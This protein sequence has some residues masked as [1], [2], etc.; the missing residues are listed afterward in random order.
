MTG[1][2][3]DTPWRSQ[4]V[5]ALTALRCPLALE[6]Y[7][8]IYEIQEIRSQSG[9]LLPLK[10][11]SREAELIRTIQND[12][13][14]AALKVLRSRSKRFF[15]KQIDVNAADEAGL[16]LLHHAAAAGMLELMN[17]LI[18]KGAAVN[19]I[20]V[21]DESVLT[22]AVLMNSE[23]PKV[24]H[25]G[26]ESDR[27]PGKKRILE[28]V[29]R[30]LAV[31]GI[32]LEIP[33]AQ[34]RTVA[35]HAAAIGDLDLMDKL[36]KAGAQFDIVSPADE[37][38]IT[39]AAKA[40]HVEAI[41]RL[42]RWGADSRPY[43]PMLMSVREVVEARSTSGDQSSSGRFKRLAYQLA[44]GEAIAEAREI[45]GL[46]VQ[47]QDL[48]LVFNDVDAFRQVYDNAYRRSDPTLSR[49][50]LNIV[51]EMEGYKEPSRGSLDATLFSAVTV[52]EGDGE[53]TYGSIW[54]AITNGANPAATNQNGLTPPMLYV[55]VG[56]HSALSL[57]QNNGA[58]WNA[59]DC[60]LNTALHYAAMGGNVEAVR[61]ML[62]FGARPDI[63]NWKG[64]T[65]RAAML[66]E[67]DYII[68]HFNGRAAVQEGVV[69]IGAPGL[70]A[71]H[72]QVQ[73]I[74]S[75]LEWAELHMEVAE[76]NF[77]KATLSH[78]TPRKA[79]N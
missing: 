55:G 58:N 60:L 7:F 1:K 59:Q 37:D 72:R 43:D 63:R 46:K 30:L 23:A 45:A 4:S 15:G 28:V 36:H 70:E 71:T 9:Y 32:D 53:H 16:S 66:A 12:D 11:D 68:E 5:I 2:K 10:T 49:V 40:G 34:D 19:A 25:S 41:R 47:G 67:R 65:P 57:M 17:E 27:G 42:Q 39:L 20:S 44:R 54:S 73:Y 77:E 22:Y 38:A 3:I 13:E 75:M 62:S 14:A 35:M 33:D 51:G 8:E 78:H 76:R 18:H 6:P 48:T 29:D 56:G 74:S 26:W 79:L 64:Q 69:K 24:Y 50:A 61:L 52:G 31:P 21:A